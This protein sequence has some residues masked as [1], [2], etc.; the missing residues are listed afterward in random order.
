MLT[1]HQTDDK[2]I[3]RVF[4]SKL[5]QRDRL[6]LKKKKKYDIPFDTMLTNLKWF[7]PKHHHSLLQL[8]HQQFVVDD[9]EQQHSTQSAETKKLCREPACLKRSDKRGY[10]PHTNAHDD[11]F[12][13]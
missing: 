7:T 1:L 11:E 2:P 12:D 13:S 6:K 8:V 4:S 3:V 10:Y 5:M 9:R